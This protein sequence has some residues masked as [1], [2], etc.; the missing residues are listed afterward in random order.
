[1][2]TFPE[3]SRYIYSASIYDS[4]LL[5]LSVSTSPDLLP[6]PYHPAPALF[7]ID[8]RLLASFAYPKHR[9]PRVSYS[10]TFTS[11]LFYFGSCSCYY[12]RLLPLLLVLR[13]LLLQFMFVLLLL[14]SSSNHRSRFGFLVLPCPPITLVPQAHVVFT[15]HQVANY[16]RLPLQTHLPCPT[17]V[18]IASKFTGNPSK[19]GFH[20]DHH[21]HSRL[22]QPFLH[23]AEI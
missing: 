3:T 14:L 23:A 19:R 13:L 18:T 10:S 15:Q 16:H 1:M 11:R 8:W 17:T 21:G 12:Y 22:L 5:L 9:I 2:E 6:L 7:D 20:I 4:Q